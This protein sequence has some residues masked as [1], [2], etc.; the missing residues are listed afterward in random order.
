MDRLENILIGWIQNR[1]LLSKPFKT[2][3]HESRTG[4]YINS[5]SQE[6]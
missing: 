6:D 1:N 4:F 3:F 2:E 5:S